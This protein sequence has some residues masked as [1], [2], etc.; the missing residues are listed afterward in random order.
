MCSRAWLLLLLL[1]LPV[2]ARALTVS[3]HSLR[4]EDSKAGNVL[5]GADQARIERGELYKTVVLVWG[6]LDISGEV[7]EVV[8]LSGHVKFH[9]GAK[10]TKSL[11]VMGGSFEAE[12]GADV[13]SQ[14]VV[15]E[16]PGPLWRMLL[17][18]GKVWREN[19][20][21]AA[22]ALGALASCL[23]LWV[24]GWAMFSAL[25]SLQAVT[26]GAL[27][28]SWARNLA[29]AV[30]GAIA[31]CVLP[32]LLLISVVG[33]ALL[34][35]YAVLLLFA[36]LVSYLAAALWAGHRLLPPKPGKRLHPLGFLLGLLA[37]QFLWVA[38]V[39]WSSLPVL[40]L[41][42]LAW[43]ALVRATARVWL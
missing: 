5:L 16:A 17:S 43:G 14:N 11:V 30:F 32:V 26:E 10:L 37:L 40:A 2:P 39:W 20:D 1:C 31:A 4:V 42:T 28:P 3:P 38:P 19:V 18:A 6:N 13:A 27:A 41:W 12:S 21:W 24:L 29:A 33:V 8:V 15:A 23:V 34:P 9:A 7:E 25:P 22:K 36:A 35:L